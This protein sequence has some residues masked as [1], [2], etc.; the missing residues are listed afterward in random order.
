V[1]ARNGDVLL[2]PSHYRLGRFCFPSLENEMTTVRTTPQHCTPRANRY[3]Q[4]SDRIMEALARGTPPWNRPW[5]MGRPM[6]AV[7]LRPY[8]SVNRLLLE[9]RAFEAGFRSSRWITY[10]ASKAQ[11]GHVNRGERGMTVL[12]FA[13]AEGLIPSEHEDASTASR[14]IMKSYTLF[15]LDQTS[16]LE[17]LREPDPVGQPDLGGERAMQLL[18]ASNARIRYGTMGAAYYP[19]LDLIMLPPSTAFTSTSAFFGTA[20]HELAHWTGAAH[21]LDRLN[22]GKFGD[23]RYA[24]EEL[25]AELTA[26][27]LCGEVGLP[28]QT[29]N[30]AA[31]I[32]SWLNL[33][34]D[35]ST[36]IFAAC[37]L[38]QQA[39]DYVCALAEPTMSQ[40]G[41]A[42]SS[43][44]EDVTAEGVGEELAMA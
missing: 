39:A 12:Y 9:L 44:S 20:F 32:R 36:A 15:N 10:S 21:R 2:R 22:A 31:Y 33:L 26:A 43:S 41:L 37:R 25:V 5:S 19:T 6:N 4:V 29:L 7:S 18:T 23:T 13:P 35:D 28:V 8:Q 30:S 1:D 11:G 38:A 16:G 17:H 40:A 34:R 42:A 14:P 27:F 24:F 3:Q